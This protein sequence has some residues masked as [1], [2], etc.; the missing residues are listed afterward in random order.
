MGIFDRG[1]NLGEQAVHRGRELGH[2]VAHD[3]RRW[4]GQIPLLDREQ[5]VAQRRQ[6]AGAPAIGAF[7]RDVADEKAEQAG[8]NRRDDLLIEAGDVEEGGK[9]KDKRRE[10]R[11]CRQDRVADLLRRAFLEPGNLTCPLSPDRPFAGSLDQT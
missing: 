8:D 4:A 6:C 7:G 10:A 5:P 1:P 3:P 9:R 11:R 2:I